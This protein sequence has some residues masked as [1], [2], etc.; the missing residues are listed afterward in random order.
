MGIRCEL[1]CGVENTGPTDECLRDPSFVATAVI[2]P[3]LGS[4]YVYAPTLSGIDSV[5]SVQS[6][7]YTYMI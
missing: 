5:H 2:Q 7:L 1:H 3:Q 4:A 6:V